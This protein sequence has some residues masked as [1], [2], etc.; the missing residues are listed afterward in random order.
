[1]S[2]RRTWMIFGVIILI[3]IAIIVIDAGGWFSNTCPCKI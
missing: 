3:L 2:E 1:M